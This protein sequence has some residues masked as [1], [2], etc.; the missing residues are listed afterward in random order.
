[1]NFCTT[2]KGRLIQ[3]LEARGL[4]A[5]IDDADDDR[6]MV[7][8]ADVY[9]CG[10]SFDN[11]N[12]LA[13]GMSDVF[14][15]V[16]KLFQHEAIELMMTADLGYE[17]CPICFLDSNCHSHC[18]DHERFLVRAGDVQLERWKTLTASGPLAP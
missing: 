2:H 9:S 12:P 11:F 6:M 13:L 4:G 17:Q 5:F 8:V 16:M 3:L 15:A 7:T 10:L 18:S 1:M 14:H